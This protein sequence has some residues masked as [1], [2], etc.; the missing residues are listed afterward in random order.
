MR[1][2]DGKGKTAE[3]VFLISASVLT[4]ALLFYVVWLIRTLVT[5]SDLVFSVDTKVGVGVKA[6]DFAGYE[7]LMGPSTST[8]AAAV[9][10][11]T[12][13]AASSTTATSTTQ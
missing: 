3:R 12:V 1:I 4:L 11:S 13:N 6:F 2:K 9:A 5:K 8:T 10:S 7:K